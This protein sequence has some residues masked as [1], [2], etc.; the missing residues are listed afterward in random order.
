VRAEVLPQEIRV[1]TLLTMTRVEHSVDGYASVLGNGL[2]GELV[3]AGLVDEG[4]NAK[5]LSH[6]VLPLVQ[7]VRYKTLTIERKG[8]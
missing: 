2:L 8:G 3:A 6:S 1:H 5:N 4:L 7:V